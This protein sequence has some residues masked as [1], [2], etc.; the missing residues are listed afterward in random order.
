MEEPQFKFNLTTTEGGNEVIIR[1]GDA[2]PPVPPIQ[3]N[4]TGDIYSVASFL[5]GRTAAVG[6]QAVDVSQAIVLVDKKNRSIELQLDPNDK[7]GTKITGKLKLTDELL[8]FHINTTKTF[9]REELVKLLRFNSR[10]FP[11][12][13]KFEQ[14]LRAYQTLNVKT[15]AELNQDSDTRGNKANHFVKTV[16]SS[17]IPDE[18]VLSVPI[19]EGFDAETFRVEIA[20]DAT[21]ASVRFWFE[22]V[23][24]HELIETRQ[25]EIIKQQLLHCGGLVIIHL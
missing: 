7:I 21:D 22:S 16:D 12:K 14:L 6:L 13:M 17:N 2:L 19:F 3:M 24:L 11:D 25:E 20:L 10:F 9:T 1:T 5:K 8:Q 18:F 23:E 4:V 15:A